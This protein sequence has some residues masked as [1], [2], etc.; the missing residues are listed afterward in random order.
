MISSTYPSQKKL[1]SVL[2]FC[3]SAL[4]MELSGKSACPQGK[5]MQSDYDT[6]LAPWR[7][8]RS[9]A[10]TVLDLRDDIWVTASYESRYLKGK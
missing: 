7:F 5:D 9:K 4:G 3:Q 8:V 2:G 1:R 6:R 10:R